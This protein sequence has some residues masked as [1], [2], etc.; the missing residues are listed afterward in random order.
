M[1]RHKNRGNKMKLKLYHGTRNKQWKP[2]EDSRFTDNYQTAV[3]YALYWSYGLRE[4]GLS[5]GVPYVFTVEA[6]FKYVGGADQ[7]RMIGNKYKII[8]I[9][10]LKVKK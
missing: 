2:G 5:Y 4:E 10:K 6:D 8:N 1:G 7:Y 3:D 9:K